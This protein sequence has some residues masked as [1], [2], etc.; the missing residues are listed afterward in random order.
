[1]DGKSNPPKILTENPEYVKSREKCCSDCKL[2]DD[3][4]RSAS[5]TIARSPN[6]ECK[7]IGGHNLFVMNTDKLGASHRYRIYFQNVD[8]TTIELLY[9]EP[10]PE[11]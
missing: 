8:D 6:D 4:T 7:Q 1:M 11:I 10:I 5:M 3:V 2:F 9:I